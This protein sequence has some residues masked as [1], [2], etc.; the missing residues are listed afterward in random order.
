MANFEMGATR[1]LAKSDT[2]NDVFNWVMVTTTSGSVIIDQ[3]GGNSITLASV[4]AGV[5]VPVGNGT[6]IQTGSTAIGLM[7]V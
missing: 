6:N 3:D 1:D 2:P 7:V 4:P 5:W